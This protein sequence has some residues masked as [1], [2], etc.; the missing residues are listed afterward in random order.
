MASS[1]KRSG[2]T[3]VE[4]L[5]V[6]AIIGVLVALML[7]AINMARE[8][9]RQTQCMNYQSEL[10]KAVVSYEGSKQHAPG[11]VNW[12][13]PMNPQNTATPLNPALKTNW[14]IAIFDQL[15]RT[16]LAGQW[17]NGVAP[18]LI[19]V[20]IDQLICP[21]NRQIAG[22][23]GLSYAANLGVYLPPVGTPPQPDFSVRM[24]RDRTRPSNAYPNPEPDLAFTALKT[25]TRTILLSEKLNVGP[26]NT[27]PTQAIPG[28]SLPV[29]C[30]LLAIGFDWPN[31]NLYPSCTIGMPYSG[32]ASNPIPTPI[33]IL[34]SNHPGVIIATFC[35]GH[36]E[37]LTPD[38]KCW[39]SANDLA[40]MATVYGT[41]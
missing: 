9:A 33:K 12:V 28:Y 27:V 34:S 41:P 20:Q 7:P 29:G 26:W 24:F 13:N 21:S 32:E 16:D 25:S 39:K 38:T 23:G 11:V 22:P 15:G 17:Q 31:P 14:I 4:M 8:S 10:G 36:A 5:V 19:A 1:K 35:D 3:L 30:Q 40:E 37:K 18:N 6:I 2:F